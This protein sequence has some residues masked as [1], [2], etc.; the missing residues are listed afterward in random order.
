MITCEQCMPDSTCC[1]DVTVEIDEPED[2]EDW[3]EI[4]WMVSHENV[5]VYKDHEDDWLI[6]FK[7]P[8]SNLD[9]AGK[10]KIYDK[11]MKTC[12]EH[13]VDSCVK[14]GEGEPHKIRFETMKQVEHYVEKRVLPQLILDT[15]DELKNLENWKWGE[16]P[17][18]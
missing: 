5:S 16:E 12:R 14:N 10:C 11:R 17:K 13:S 3:D 8:C 9:K 18:N 2:M 7:T 4:R 1:R 15:R 6:E